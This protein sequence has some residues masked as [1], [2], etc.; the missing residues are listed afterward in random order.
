MTIGASR[1]VLGEDFVRTAQAKGLSMRRTL[2]RH[3]FPVAAIPVLVLTAAQVNL[4]I[5]NIGL[6]Q[7]A[8]NIPGSLREMKNALDN[9]D[10]DM[11]QALVV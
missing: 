8:F 11:L 7:I 5:T 6:M 1:D 10:A 9:G 3:V 4:L 2:I